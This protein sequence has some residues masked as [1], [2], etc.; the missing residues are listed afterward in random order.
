MMAVM[1]KDE[2]PKFQNSKFLQ[3]L[4]KLSS[5]VNKIENN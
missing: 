1:M 2:D 5:G 3:F 4:S